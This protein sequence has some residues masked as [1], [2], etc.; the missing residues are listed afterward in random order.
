MPNFDYELS[1]DLELSFMMK[2]KWI[3]VLSNILALGNFYGI[4]VVFK[5]SRALAKKSN[6]IG[7]RKKTH[8]I[9]EQSRRTTYKII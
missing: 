1:L 8:F 2:M 3:K 4:T 9:K 7:F 5:N 6:L